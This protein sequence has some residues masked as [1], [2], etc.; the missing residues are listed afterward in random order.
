ML[1]VIG[2]I[3]VALIIAYMVKNYLANARFDPSAPKPV[4]PTT[5]KAPSQSVPRAAAGDRPLILFGSQT[6]TAE[7]FAKTLQREGAR[8]G[9]DFRNEDVEDYSLNNLADE[10]LIVFVMATYGEGEP[11]DSAKNFY[12]HITSSDRLPGEFEGVKYCVFGLGDRQYPKY[13]Q[14]GVD[15]D[16]TM[17]KLGAQRIYG[18]GTGDAGRSLE[19]DWDSWRVDLWS[20]LANALGMKLKLAGDEPVAPELQLKTFPDAKPS[21]FAFPRMS[22]GLEPTHRQPAFVKVK[23]NRELLKKPEGRSTRHIVFDISDTSL[24]Y[25]AGDHLGVLSCNPDDVVNEYLKILDIDDTMANTVIALVDERRKNM[26]P[27]KVTVRQAL[28]W[29]PDLCGI[30]KKSA[31]RAFAHYCKDPTEKAKMQEM[32][33]VGAGAQAKYHEFIQSARTVLGLLKRFP[34]CKIPLGHFL[35]LMPHIAPRYFSIASD[36]L[37]QPQEIYITVALVEGGLCTQMLGAMQPGAEQPVFVRKSNFH[38][39]LRHKTRPLIFIG[40][41]TGV[42]PLIGFCHRRAAWLAKNQTLGECMMFFGC[43]RKNEDYIYEDFLKEC[44]GNGVLTSLS[45]AFSREQ[46]EKRYVQHDIAERG[47]KIWELIGTGSANIYICGDA[48]HMARDVE[49]ALKL[50]IQKYG[51]KSPKEADEYLEKLAKSEHYLKDVWSA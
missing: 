20:A 1:E 40:P 6:G 33:V 5:Q 27:A 32:L 28:K 38:L 12:D 48:K 46:E 7:M 51:G 26:L 50:I 29:Y 25:Q 45:V 8:Q 30:P 17:A 19:E 35:E 23:E 42:A 31:L 13:C 24:S 16:E 21:D 39:P 14:M 43:R 47:E 9:I 10:K 2:T 41:G 49:A 37:R 15:I 18:L 36:Q 3:V 4:S 34:S 44:A 22:L 11:T